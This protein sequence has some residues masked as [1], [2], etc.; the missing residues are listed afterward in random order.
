MDR[1]RHRKLPAGAE[2]YEFEPLT[3]TMAPS[4]VYAGKERKEELVSE[5]ESV[6]AARDEVAVSTGRIAKKVFDERKKP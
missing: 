1:W 3:F 6:S 5:P 4:G 2:V